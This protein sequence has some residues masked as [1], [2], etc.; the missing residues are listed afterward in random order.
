MSYRIQS[1]T[2][3]FP[4]FDN[5]PLFEALLKG[6]PGAID[7][8]WRFDTMPCICAPGVEVWVDSSALNRREFSE[9]RTFTLNGLDESGVP[10]KTICETD[11][12]TDAIYLAEAFASR[13]KS[14]DSKNLCARFEFFFES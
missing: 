2:E 8:S 6:I 13:S 11:S 10:T 14:V 12:F 4:G 5:Q 7:A 3:E 1:V 9:S